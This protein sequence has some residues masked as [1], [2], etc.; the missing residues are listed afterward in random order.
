MHLLLSKL[1]QIL[2]YELSLPKVA[3]FISIIFVHGLQGDPEGTWT[4]KDQPPEKKALTVEKT[5]KKAYKKK[6]NWKK[7]FGGKSE[8]SNSS[9]PIPSNEESAWPQT[10]IFWPGQLLPSSFPNCRILTYGY[11]SQISNFF[12]GAADQSHILAQ[13]RDFLNQLEAQRRDD[14]AKPLSRPIIFV[15]HSLGGIVVKEAL[16]QAEGSKG[17]YQL[18]NAA[19]FSS[20]FAILFFGTPHRGA[21]LAEWGD[22]VRNVV[23]ALGFDT[24]DKLLK[25][26]Q[27]DSER[28]EELREEF[29]KMLFGQNWFIYSFQ[30]SRGVIGFRGL[31]DKVFLP[32][33]YIG[34]TL[35]F[36]HL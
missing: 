24:N 3:I 2:P 5:D 8:A 19:I 18:N 30:E 11:A 1:A 7:L 20:T 27:P 13:G 35:M 25:G 22:I 29:G 21:S 4:R 26:L 9:T 32:R 31:N 36:Q 16:R 17:L 14:N 23:G 10:S 33:S 6:F 28:L 12:K 15:A 34:N